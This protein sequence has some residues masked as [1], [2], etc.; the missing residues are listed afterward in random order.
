MLSD[1]NFAPIPLSIP[2][3]DSRP[4][5]DFLP[6]L[7]FDD[8]LDI[9]REC[10]FTRTITHLWPC[11]ESSETGLEDI[12]AAI[13][14]TPYAE[15]CPLPLSRSTSS[16]NPD[17]NLPGVDPRR[18][19]SMYP[20][21]DS[22]AS[23]SR[24][25]ALL[26]S[27]P[28][29]DDQVQTKMKPPIISMLR[30]WSPPNG[31]QFVDLDDN[32]NLVLPHSSK[33]E[34]VSPWLATCLELPNTQSASNIGQSFAVPEISHVQPSPSEEEPK[35]PAVS[36]I[37]KAVDD[38]ARKCL[39]QGPLIQ[40]LTRAILEPVGAG[41]G[42]QPNSNVRN[43]TI[44]TPYA[45]TTKSRPKISSVPAADNTSPVTYARAPRGGIPPHIA[46]TVTKAN[47]LRMEKERKV[48]QD[49]FS[50]AS[51]G[52]GKKP[53]VL[54][55]AVRGERE[56]GKN[57]NGGGTGKESSELGKNEKEGRVAKRARL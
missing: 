48:M 45:K 38:P 42:L 35:A 12:L 2:C 56:T 32:L 37:D 54:R 34:W 44:T 21:P 23:L 25:L 22:N 20:T 6:T 57:V 55:R 28:H 27:L 14:P 7:G 1:C 40:H 3:P 5:E 9:A 8:I 53:S 4:D 50:S 51:T 49:A 17:P 47:I 30:G 15:E 19:I 31:S 29:V 11:E 24:E 46:R 26:P 52:E 39:P 18:T 43:Q 36:K 13:V 33:D 16:M 41:S 10:E